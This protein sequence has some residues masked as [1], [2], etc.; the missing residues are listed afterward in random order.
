ML[1]IG[2]ANY[3]SWDDD[4]VVIK[5]GEGIQFEHPYHPLQGSP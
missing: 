4:V 1:T 5:S 3:R 2:E